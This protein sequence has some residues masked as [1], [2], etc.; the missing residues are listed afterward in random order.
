MNDFK[1]A[2]MRL[3]TYFKLRPLLFIIEENVFASNVKDLEN[4]MSSAL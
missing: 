1:L 2:V 4:L 3:P